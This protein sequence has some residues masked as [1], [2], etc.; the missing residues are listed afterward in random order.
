MRTKNLTVR[1]RP[2]NL[3]EALILFAKLRAGESVLEESAQMGQRLIREIQYLHR[4]LREVRKTLP[5]SYNDY[6][7]PARMDTALARTTMDGPQQCHECGGSGENPITGT[8]CSTC[9]GND[10]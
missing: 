6:F 2:L 3:N 7:D 4:V 8:I 10:R 9:H 5:Q 1:K